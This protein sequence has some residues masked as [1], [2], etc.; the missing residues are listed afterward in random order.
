MS[1]SVLI[2]C[3]D[4]HVVYDGRT[5][6]EDGIGG[7]VTARVRIGRALASLGISVQMAVNC[8]RREIIDGVEYVPLGKPVKAADV[9]VATTSGGAFDLEPLPSGADDAQLKIAWLHGPE[10]P[11]GLDR[12]RPDVVYTV[13]NFVCEEIHK[14]W[15]PGDIPTFVTYNGLEEQTFESLQRQPPPRNPHRLVYASHP[16]KGLEAATAVLSLL[17]RSDERFHLAVFGGE[18]LWGQVDKSRGNEPGIQY[19]GRIGQQ[20]LAKELMASSFSLN[21]QTRHEPF[22]Y[23]VTE[24]MRAGCVVIASA[25]GA[26]PELIRNGKNGFLVDGADA[27]DGIL[28]RAADIVLSCTRDPAGTARIRRAARAV[29]WTAERMARTW[30]EHWAHL[31]G[32]H[33]AQAESNAP[34]RTCGAST[35]TLADGQH[36]MSC[37]HIQ[38]PNWQMDRGMTPSDSASARSKED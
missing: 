21:L 37:G 35:L 9:L 24:A 12:L 1:L 3:P 17:R 28:S 26:F 4:A 19:F 29:P 25:V 18:S 8:Q 16:S 36:C 14:K 33:T 13:S 6:D 27:S 15:L 34:C 31:L 23:V 20:R 7:G 5:P 2:T 38:R 30:L 32:E 10:E 11:A 22:G